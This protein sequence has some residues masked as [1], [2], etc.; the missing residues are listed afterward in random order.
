MVCETSHNSR[1]E[2]QNQ[3]NALMSLLCPR[4]N[5]PLKETRPGAICS[6]CDGC[7]L[8]FEEMST[9]LELPQSDLEQSGLA[10]TLVADHPEISLQPAI[11]CPSCGMAMRRFNYM[12][13]SGVVVDSCSQHGMWLDDGELAK[14][15]DYLTQSEKIFPDEL[16]QPSKLSFFQRLFG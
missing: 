14:I 13:D 7:W 9:V 4:C 8:S 12:M 15:R 2:P 16:T 3:E 10:P 6:K 1:N 5:Q 11:D